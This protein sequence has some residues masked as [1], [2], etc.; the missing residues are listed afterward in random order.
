ML[1]H[2]FSANFTINIAY[3]QLYFLET[4]TYNVLFLRRI[5]IGIIPLTR[6]FCIILLQHIYFKRNV[7]CSAILPISD[8][9][10]ICIP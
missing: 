8:S 9:W 5:D 2:F 6:A 10:C 3:V 1:F 4:F 7:R